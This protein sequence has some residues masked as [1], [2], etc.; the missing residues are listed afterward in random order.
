MGAINIDWVRRRI[1]NCWVF[2][3]LWI[4]L[5]SVNESGNGEFA[6]LLGQG[7]IDV[8]AFEVPDGAS[9]EEIT[10]E[11]FLAPIID[12]FIPSYGN[13]LLAFAGD[14]FELEFDPTGGFGYDPTYD[15][16][17]G[18]EDG[19]EYG[20][21]MAPKMVLQMI[22]TSIWPMIRIWAEDGSENGTTDDSDFDLT[23]DLEYGPEDGSKQYRW[24][25]L[26]SDR[27]F[28]IWAGEGD[29]ENGL[30]DSDF[31][32]TDESGELQPNRVMI[33]NVV[34]HMIPNMGGRWLGIRS[35]DDSDFDLT[36]ESGFEPSD[37]SEYDLPQIPNMGRRWLRKWYYRWFRL[38]LTMIS[39]GPEDSSENGPTDDSDFDLS[40]F[41][42]FGRWL[43]KWSYRWF[44]LRSDR[45]FRIWAG[46]WLENDPTDDSNT[47]LTDDSNM[48][49]KMAPK[50]VLQ[51]IQTSIQPMIW[52]W[53]EGDLKMVLQM[54][55]TS[56]RP[57]ISNMGG[58]WLE[59]GPTDDSDFDLT[60]D[61]DMG[62]RW[63]RK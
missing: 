40:D 54:I 25:R 12:N 5:V 16:E 36:D 59:N 62:G 23:D 43:R 8:I 38:K 60:D 15:S 11:N 21:K 58:R 45:W 57:M 6:N 50:M 55:Q 41:G 17:Y 10:L 63:L 47:D 24:F 26:R 44:R 13:Y 18:P 34:I 3:L 39:N 28:R 35:T 32:L 61:S 48:G 46:R 49:R 31:D 37:D 51:M 30:N 4:T 20:R 19:S 33:Q 7:D 29:K 14:S 2:G 52:I 22:Q 42:A 1:L 9:I 27:W 56:I 53:A